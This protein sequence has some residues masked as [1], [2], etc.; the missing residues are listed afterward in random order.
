MFGRQP[1]ILDY[2][3]HCA[4]KDG[5]RQHLRLSS[6][7]TRAAYDEAQRRWQVETADGA[8]YCARILV[9]ATGTISNTATV[10]AP[11][12]TTDPDPADNSATDGGADMSLG[13]IPQAQANLLQVNT[14]VAKRLD[15][16]QASMPPDMIRPEPF[17]VLL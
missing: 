4:D 12:G 3:R 6:E 5:L 2:L 15:E 11:A 16:L 1:E 8:R 7:V 14:D 10:T 17:W 9:A 13:I